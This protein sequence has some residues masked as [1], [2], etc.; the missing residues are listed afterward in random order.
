MK[1]FLF[2]SI[3]LITL[4]SN[5]EE[6][7]DDGFNDN[8][9]EIII[10][11]TP[12]TKGSAYGSINLEAHYNFNNNKNLSSA[13]FLLDL[14]TDYKMDNGFKINSNIK[15]YHD[16]IFKASDNY[17][18]TPSG[19]ENELNIN[20][21]N[22]EGSINTNLDFKVG[23]Q[24]IVWGKSDSIRITDILNPLDN[25]T[26]GLVDIKNLRLGRLMSKLDYYQNNLKFSAI[27]LHENR[28]SKSPKFGSDFKKST[29][30]S[31]DKADN[32]L[33][34]TG[35]ALSL[36]GEFSGYDFG[37][38]FADTYLDKPYFNKGVLQFDN[39][40]KMLG[41][42]YNKVLSSFLLKTEIAYFNNIKYAK[43]NDTRSRI[44]ALIG[45][46]YTGI[47]DGSI[48]YELALRKINR[49]DS[50]INTQFNNFTQQETYQHTLRFTQSYL[51][52]TL[53]LTAISGI[54]GKQG[55]AG[56]LARISLDYAIDDKLSI[57]GG[58]IDYM[59][60][61]IGTD[62]IKN[63]DRVFTKISYDF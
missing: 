11:T 40:S 47:S 41:L 38:Y 8:A 55:D 16:F 17:T 34:N 13:K 56:G 6:G 37:I 60:G 19:Y 18:T 10:Q 61:S 46:E 57:R 44:D 48:S 22:I 59:G 30:L 35:I 63:N 21:L 7:F 27:L 12:P 31:E 53:N 51:N 2:L 25:R 24:I 43:L 14:T 42:A 3:F 49:Y 54:F 28:F 52:Q 33:K 58:I 62:L 50:I 29:D 32:S 45:I 4:S 5:A 1:F 23:R 9:D 39:Q 15:A 36:T 26:P 20:E